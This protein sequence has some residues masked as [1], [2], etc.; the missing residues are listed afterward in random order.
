MARSLKKGPFV[1]E[2]LIEKM[3]KAGKGL[4]KTWSRRCTIVP[5]MAGSTFGVHNGKEFISVKVSEDMVGHKLGEFSPTT[6]F[7]RHGGKMQRDLETKAATGAVAAPAA[8]AGAKAKPA[9]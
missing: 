6:R 8:A 4:V 5:E 3:R 9:K 2:K 1:D 7:H